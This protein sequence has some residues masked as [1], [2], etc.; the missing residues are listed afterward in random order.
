MVEPIVYLYFGIGF[1]VAGLLVLPFFPILHNR[2]VRLTMRR[3]E[4][5]PSRLIDELRDKDQLRATFATSTRRLEMSA[6]RMKAQITPQLAELG[7]KTD[8][9]NRLKKELDQKNTTLYA[10]ELRTQNLQDRLRGIEEGIELKSSLLLEAEHALADN[11]AEFTKLGAELGQCS[12]TVDRHSEELAALRTQGDTAALR[13][14][15]YKR[16]A[17]ATAERLVQERGAA[18]AATKA[19]DEARRKL[20]GL[21]A[22]TGELER[23]L[24]EQTTKTD[25]LRRR[26]PNLEMQLGDQVHLLA[27]RESQIERL[28]S[29]LVIAHKTENVLRGAIEERSNMLREIATMKGEAETTRAALRVEHAVLRERIID[30]VA[31]MV[32]FIARHEAPGSPI[33]SLLAVEAAPLSNGASGANGKSD[34]SRDAR[35][36]PQQPRNIPLAHR[37]GALQSGAS[38]V[39]LN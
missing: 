38:R 10:L 11:E 5:K 26:L 35:L 4:T 9:V 13:I 21:A 14:A 37:T 17:K 39:A 22:H 28:R 30:I 25:I 1:L 31:E 20:D 8:A 23:Q 33:E 18:E 36:D 34:G 19:L 12:I 2:A 32:H 29:D 6:E 3:I 24:A 16:A 15:D 7:R 27:E